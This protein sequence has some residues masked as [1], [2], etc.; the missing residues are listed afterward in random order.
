MVNIR[1]SQLIFV[2]VSLLVLCLGLL[3]AEISHPFEIMTRMSRALY[4]DEGFYAD[5]AQNFVNFGHWDMPYDSRHWPGAPALVFIQTIVFSIF[6]ASLTAARGISMVFGL[7]SIV[8][9]YMMLKRTLPGWLAILSALLILIT[10]NFVAHARAAIA[11]PVA[12]GFALLA[13]MIYVCYHDRKF[14]ISLSLVL[15]FMALMSKMYFLFTLATLFFVWL[16]EFIAIPLFH[17]HRVNVAGLIRLVLT[18]VI[19]VVFYLAIRTLFQAEFADFFAINNNKVPSLDLHFLYDRFVIAVGFLPVHTKTHIFLIGLIVGALLCIFV[20]L[21]QLIRSSLPALSNI[22]DLRADL[23]LFSFLFSGMV[24]V[25]S[26]NLPEKTHYQYFS[27]VPIGGLCILWLWRGLPKSIFTAVFLG[28]FLADGYFQ[29]S[30][31][32]RWINIEHKTVVSDISHDFV[33]H[34]HENSSDEIIPV[35][36][37][38]S[39]QLALFSDNIL[40][41]DVKWADKEKLC[42][43][44]DHWKP[45]FNV[46]LVWPGSRMESE[47]WRIR[48]C[49]SI[50]DIVQVK[51]ERVYGRYSEKLVLNEIVYKQN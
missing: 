26:L 34:I 20:I 7:I 35:I 38:Y 14:A 16:V 13:M 49:E 47:L 19:L 4:V 8:C 46:N 41:L 24:T 5:A 44:V 37:E 39:A 36:G 27:I 3:T 9:L 33:N 23:V 12:T 43:R 17:K 22:P 31:Y 29:F 48:E 6:G 11:D 28:V 2:L 25:A 10:F 42:E 50:E 51:L 40:S 1:L 30:L 21:Y 15:A 18:L 45:K 32:K